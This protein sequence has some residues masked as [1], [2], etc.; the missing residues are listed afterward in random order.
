[1]KRILVGLV[2]LVCC[3]SGLQAETVIRDVPKTDAAYGAVKRS[4]DE[5]YL[6]LY[7]DNS[8]QSNQAVSRKEL[9]LALDKL[10][11]TLET[12]NPLL[13]AAQIE[14]LTWLAKTF[15]QYLA[16]SEVS[17]NRLKNNVNVL[18]GDQKALLAGYAQLKESNQQL[19]SQNA[20]LTETVAALKKDNESQ[21]WYMWLAI[22]VAGTMGIIIH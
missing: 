11:T 2:V 17:Q 5:G 6:S 12:Q 19:A 16:D 3:G 4:V 18:D 20:S 10:N 22:A 21:H 15:K 1:M 8:F 9:A 14:D 7:G 13:T